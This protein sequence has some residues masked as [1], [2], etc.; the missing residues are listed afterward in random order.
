MDFATLTSLRGFIPDHFD[1]RRGRDQGQGRA[2]TARSATASPG[3]VAVRGEPRSGGEPSGEMIESGRGAWGARGE[4][5]H[6][7]YWPDT[8]VMPS[9]IWA[10]TPKSTGFGSTGM[11]SA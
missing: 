2:H 11:P 10:N 3:R 8:V 4:A 9:T 7:G 1:G 6:V 5:P